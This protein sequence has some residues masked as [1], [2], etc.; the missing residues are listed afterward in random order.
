MVGVETGYECASEDT[1]GKA[2]IC[3]FFVV[4]GETI[5]GR[6]QWYVSNKMADEAAR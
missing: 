5:A 6:G 2:D 4:R 3:S 1:S